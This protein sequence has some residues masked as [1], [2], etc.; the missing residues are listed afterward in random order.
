MVVT[1]VAVVPFTLFIL[2]KEMVHEHHHKV[3]YSHMHQ[4]HKAFPWGA[5]DCA[6]FDLECKR[7]AKHG[8]AAHAAHH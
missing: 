8:G 1:A 5:S 7:A 4:R 6:L 3:D 2:Y